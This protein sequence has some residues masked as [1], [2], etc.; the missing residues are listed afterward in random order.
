MTPARKLLIGGCV[1]VG[2]TAYMAY[3]GAS[4][5]WKYYVTT[6]ECAAGAGQFVGQRLRVS[7]KI[8]P[9]SL[10][11]AADRRQADFVLQGTAAQLAVTCSGLLPDNLAEAMDVVVEGRLASPGLLRGEKVLTRCAS[12]YDPQAAAAV[13]ASIPAPERKGGP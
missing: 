11:I 9:Q 13:P 3:V 1:V 10:H 8:A 2:V 12:K 7:G 4:A 6:D 5:S